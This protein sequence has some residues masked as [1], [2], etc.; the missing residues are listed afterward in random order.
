MIGRVTTLVRCAQQQ[1]FR[2]AAFFE[3]PCASDRNDAVAEAKPVECPGAVANPQN[4]KLEGAWDHDPRVDQA[5]SALV[6]LSSPS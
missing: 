4:P 2:C 5:G 6:C 3:F 1:A